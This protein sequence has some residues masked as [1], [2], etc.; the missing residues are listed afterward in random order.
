[1]QTE[2]VIVE[3]ADAALRLIARREHAPWCKDFDKSFEELGGGLYSEV[4]GRDDVPHVV[5][6]MRAYDSGYRNYAKTIATL[7]TNNPY[8]PKIFRTIVYQR[9]DSYYS[10]GDTPGECGGDAIVYYI[11]RLT[12]ARAP[13]PGSLEC[14]VRAAKF[15]EILKDMLWDARTG[16]EQWKKLRPVHQELV[17]VLIIAM[18][19]GGKDGF[20]LHIGNVMKRGSRF[21]ITDPLA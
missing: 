11:E 15:V 5:K 12:N 7:N 9:N 13:I 14:R 19:A 1:M 10:E 21:V 3:E 18:E 6:V 16:G 20:D 2:V 4:Y 8:L 17:W